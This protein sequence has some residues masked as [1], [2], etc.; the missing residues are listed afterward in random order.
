MLLKSDF[1]RTE[2]SLVPRRKNLVKCLWWVS[3]IV[4][5]G[6]WWGYQEVNRSSSQ[7]QAIFVLGGHENR[8]RA[9]AKLAERY[10][11]LPIWV[12]SGSPENYVK[13]IFRRAGVESRRLH[14]SYQARDT[15]TNFTSLVDTMKAQGIH[16]VYL[17]TS[18]NHMTRA[19]LVGEI[20]FGSRGI[21][22][23]PIAVPSQTS[24]E[25]PDKC[26]RDILRSLLWVT[27][28][29]TGETLLK[30]PS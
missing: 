8:E 15:V 14:L 9:A 3:P 16:S 13:R 5:L 2:T 26:V 28:G 24:Q 4:A 17:V 25:S 27:T 22:L 19:R 18:E 7:P 11:H 6:L 20:V 29:R 12:S 10:P 30:P 1:R 23:N 21:S